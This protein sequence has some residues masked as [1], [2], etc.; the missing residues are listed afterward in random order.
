[1]DNL[2]IDIHSNKLLG[3]NFLF[4][5]FNF[6]LDWLISRRHCSKNWQSNFD[7][8]RQK[9]S[10][11][12]KD[13]PE[14]EQIIKIL[15]G[16]QFI[17]YFHCKE[18]LKI[19][20]ETEKDTKNIFGFYSSQRI[21]D[22]KVCFVR[23]FC[24]ELKFFLRKL[25]LFMK[26]F[27]WENLPIFYSVM[28]NMRKQRKQNDY[29]KLAIESNRL[30]HQELAKWGLNKNI[31]NHQKQQFENLH[32]NLMLIAE[33]LP[34]AEILKIEEI[35]KA[36]DYFCCFSQQIGQETNDLFPLLRI[37]TKDLNRP[38][39]DISVYEWKYGRKPDVLLPPA[40]VEILQTVET[41][42]E[43]DEIDFGDDV[44]IAEI[45]FCTNGDS[46][47]SIQIISSDGIDVTN[48]NNDNN[49]STIVT[50]KGEEALPVLEHPLTCGIFLDEISI[51]TGFLHF[52]IKDE[53]AID[54]NAQIY[55]SGIAQKEINKLTELINLPELKCW[56]LNLQNIFNELGNTQRLQLLRLRTSKNFVNEI[57]SK[58]EQKMRLELKYRQLQQLSVEKQKQYF[59]E[60]QKVNILLQEIIEAAK[61]LQENLEADISSK[62]NGRE[63]YI[64]GEI[65]AVLYG[66]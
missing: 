33:S 40:L 45:D 35:K 5:K 1:M 34:K 13:M 8:I 14:N 48:I 23:F 39:S 16:G 20:Y 43:S 55:L 61:A 18:I 19:L 36:L 59:E 28:F 25:F 46:D 31:I 50:A 7:E 11:A 62:Y 51:L 52:R 54:G 37:L 66:N 64:M 17:N 58:I 65:N 63:V 12:I 3:L 57:C 30:F 42:E 26:M 47:E 44:D 10:N 2:P 56:L 49:D 60:S 6:L 29:S 38:V 22:W 27:I 4:L 9:I 41:K 32:Y 24:W 15:N 21:K 53:C